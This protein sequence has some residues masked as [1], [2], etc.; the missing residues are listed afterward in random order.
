[1]ER[2]RLCAG[3]AG[4]QVMAAVLEAPGVDGRTGSPTSWPIGR[5]L[6]QRGVSLRPHERGAARDCDQQGLAACLARPEVALRR[7]RPVASGHGVARNAG[8]DRPTEPLSRRR[9]RSHDLTPHVSGW[10]E[11]QP[12]RPRHNRVSIRSA[13]LRNLEIRSNSDL[14]LSVILWSYV[15]VSVA[16]LLVAEPPVLVNTALTSQPFSKVP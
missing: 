15:T 2:L 13:T 5:I 9:R 16:G 3:R 14:T 12:R 8:S 11:P 6:H 7:R 1:M 4:D 10:S